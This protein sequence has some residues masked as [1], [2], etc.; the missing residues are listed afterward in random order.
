MCIVFIRKV[1]NHQV[2]MASRAERRQLWQ[3]GDVPAIL[4][5]GAY[6]GP[7]DK[8]TFHIVELPYVPA[9]KMGHLLTEALAADGTYLGR[10][11]EQIMLSTLHTKMTV[12]ERLSFDAGD[13]ITTLSEGARKLNES[14]RTRP[15]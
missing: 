1:N 8:V 11:T 2:A 4:K 6:V 15:T 13:R 7:A 9:R 10:R 5:S 14:T 12:A 3:A